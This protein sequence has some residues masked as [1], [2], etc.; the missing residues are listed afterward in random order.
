LANK[1]KPH[2]LVTAARI[3]AEELLRHG[4]DRIACVP[5]ESYLS[6]LDAMVDFPSISL[7]TC[8]H[9][10]GAAMMAEA[11]G[12]L[13][14]RPGIVFAT[15]GP[16]ATN[17]SSGIHVAR[18]DSTPV[19]LFVGQIERASRG[20]EAFQEI[21]LPAVFG[22]LAKWVTEIDD[23]SRLAE[24]VARAFHVATS[25]RPGPVV[26]G[27]PEDMLDTPVPPSPTRTRAYLPATAMM[28]HEDADAI[29]EALQKCQRPFVIV[30]GGGWSRE[31]SFALRRFAE[32][33][34]LPVA[35]TFRCQDYLDNRSPSYAGNLGLGANPALLAA[36]RDSD[37]ILGLGTRLED[38]STNA[39]TLFDLPQPS[40]RIIH[41]HPDA[42]ELGHV[43]Q[44]WKAI[45]SGAGAAASR[46]EHLESRVRPHWSERTQ[47]LRRG[48]EG[49]TTPPAIGGPLQVGEII[50][51][52]RARLADDATI[53][54]GAG[55][56]AIWP[57]R[58][59]RYHEFGGMLAPTSGSMGY[60]VPAAVAAKIAHPN[61]TVIAFTGD[62]DFLMTGQ[63]LATAARQDAPIIVILINNGMYGTIRMHQ[64]ARYPGRVSATA[65]S[66]PDFVKLAEAYGAWGARITRTADFESALSH[67]LACGK[68]V[69]LELVLDPEI[70]SPTQTVT[71]LRSASRVPR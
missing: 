47:G 62:G 6:L 50:T 64:E 4:V 15:R 51:M 22:T 56:F 17:A 9:E 30:G 65:L 45:V 24:I 60:A 68:S 5:G 19:I 41:I 11:W 71:S 28:T 49:W 57:N 25:G 18:Q 43:Y 16:G 42:D 48:Y 69:L 66:N 59:F 38:V 7:V 53:T 14:G 35:T 33:W 26:I 54:N 29:G 3:L 8:R 67:A 1:E 21:D 39:F 55:N 52:L 70:I 44:P 10:G 31:A 46:L 37:L 63:E 12:K 13:T 34:D 40:Q 23:P 58:Y 20:R 36:I 27:L 32:R 61:R 2:G